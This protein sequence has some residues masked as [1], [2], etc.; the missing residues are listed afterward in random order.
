MLLTMITVSMK[1]AKIRWLQLIKAVHERGEIV[2]IC[3]YGKPVAVMKALP[4]KKTDRLT[5]NPDLKPI[6][7]NYDPTEPLA[8]EEWPE[9]CR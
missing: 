6:S 2:I 7:I 1:Q 3:R 9:E 8:A 4:G 5:P